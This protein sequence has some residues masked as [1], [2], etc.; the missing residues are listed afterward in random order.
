MKVAELEEQFLSNLVPNLLDNYLGYTYDEIW[1]HVLHTNLRAQY[2][3]LSGTGGPDD[4]APGQTTQC[5]PTGGDP[6]PWW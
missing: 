5:Q 6:R 4:L 2:L 1:E 3:T